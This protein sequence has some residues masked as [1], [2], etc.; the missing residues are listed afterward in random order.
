MLEW[1]SANIATI[2]IS[3]ALAA[4]V[5]LAVGKLIRDRKRSGCSCGC[6]DCPMKGKCCEK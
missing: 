5:G 3:L 6:S 4:V 2:L 1:L